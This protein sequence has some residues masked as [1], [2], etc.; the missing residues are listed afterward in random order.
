MNINLVREQFPYL[1]TGKIYFNHAAVSP[2]PKCSVEIL[3]EYF[4]VRSKGEIEN[5]FSFQKTIIETKELIGKWINSD[6]NRIAFVDN[7]SNG[8]NILAQGLDWNVGDRILLYNVEF[9]SNVYPFM[10]LKKYGVELDF[11][12]PTNGRIEFGDIEKNIQPQTKLLTLSHVQFL[13]GFRADLKTIGELCRSKGIIFCVD[14][15]QSVGA[16]PVDVEE[17]KIDLMSCGV[18]KWL[19]S[20]E[21]TAFI[22]LT[23]E[24]QERINQKYVGWTSV[25]NAWDIL[26]YDL[27]LADTARRFENGAMNFPG[28]ASLNS[29]IKMFESFGLNEVHKKIISN[30]EYLIDE[31][32]KLGISPSFAAKSKEEL[33]GIVSFKIE[34]VNKLN[35]DL[36]ANDIHCAVREGF[37]RIS[38]HFYN[39]INEFNKLID[40]V[41]K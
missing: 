1:K 13:N 36:L 7:T 9:P 4:A 29:A 35:D 14:G 38:P 21:G 10:N 3:K 31:L 27:T 24:M 2:I 39:D 37:L 5:Y 33:S 41:K 15:I 8:L 18:Y 6:K 22:F 19:M 34:E 30:S 20:V 23:E 16:V 11:I 28:I 17:M 12:S 25:K 26:N 40:L 32:G